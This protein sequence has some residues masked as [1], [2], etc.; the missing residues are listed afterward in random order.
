MYGTLFAIPR[1]LD[2]YNH[3]TTLLSIAFLL[4]A[5]SLLFDVFV[6]WIL[7]KYDSSDL[8]PCPRQVICYIHA[9]AIFWLLGAG[10]VVLNFVF[11]AIGQR[12]VGIIGL[13]FL[14][15]IS[16]TVVGA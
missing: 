8:L 4:F 7:R 14:S 6:H 5:T 12:C 1:T 9:F 10:F 11:I 13:T 2:N 3:I 15:F 16:Y